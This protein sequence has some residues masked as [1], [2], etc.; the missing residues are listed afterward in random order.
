VNDHDLRCKEIRR[1]MTFF[2]RYFCQIANA[3]IPRR[4]H[5]TACRISYDRNRPA[6][7]ACWVV[8]YP[9]LRRR[10]PPWDPSQGLEQRICGKARNSQNI[11]LILKSLMMAKYIDVCISFY[12]V[13]SV[14]QFYLY[15]YS[16]IYSSVI[17]RE[18]VDD[19]LNCDEL[20]QRL[21][22]IFRR[23]TT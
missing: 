5:W 19:F 7:G 23:I 10:D 14:L 2:T 1:G 12:L 16:L 22:Y 9:H 13:L 3:R 4:R 17:T 15:V 21:L 20:I 8:N 11:V 6:A 18:D